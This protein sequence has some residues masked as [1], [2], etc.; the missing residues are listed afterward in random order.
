MQPL[1]TF[2]LAGADASPVVDADAAGDDDPTQPYVNVDGVDPTVSDP[3]RLLEP[4]A[5]TT[6]GA[7]PSAGSNAV[8]Q[9]AHTPEGESPSNPMGVSRAIKFGGTSI[10]EFDAESPIGEH[11]ENSPT[12]LA[13][14]GPAD[15][16][17]GG[18]SVSADR[19]TTHAADSRRAPSD[20]GCALVAAHRAAQS[21][22]PPARH[23]FSKAPYRGLCWGLIREPGICNSAKTRARRGRGGCV[24]GRRGQ[25]P[26]PTWHRGGRAP[27]G[28]R[29]R[30]EP[31]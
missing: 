21:G 15:S 30:Q 24:F 9:G 7:V 10:Y 2:P 27:P 18:G 29:P 17:L 13:I 12:P 4:C 26:M 11:V 5:G 6:A 23:G 25:P 1:R 14:P 16:G 3:W 28:R 8:P 22:F 19:H 20:G 31:G